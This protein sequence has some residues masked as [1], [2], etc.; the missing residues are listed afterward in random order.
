M[1]LLIVNGAAA[2]AQAVAP[3]MGDFAD[4]NGIWYNTGKRKGLVKPVRYFEDFH[5]GDIFELGPLRVT[6]EEIIAFA[7][8]F[9]PQYFHTDPQRAGDSFF[10]EL[11]AS[12]WHTCALFMRMF[13][14]DLLGDTASMGSPGLDQIRWLKPARPNDTLRGRFTVTDARSSK[15]RPTVGILISHCEVFNQHNELLMT[16]DGTHFIGKALSG[17][18]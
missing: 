8:Q 16:L 14:D 1:H 12:G 11:V 3:F 17:Y 9:D 2:R 5:V 18:P 13:V 6:Q 4:R 7:K 15:S 10:G